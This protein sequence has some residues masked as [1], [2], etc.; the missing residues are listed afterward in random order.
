MAFQEV[1]RER[2][3]RRRAAPD[4]DALPPDLAEALDDLREARAEAREEG[5]PEPSDAALSNADRL[6]RAMYGIWPR[7]YWIYP[8]PD[9]EIA[10]DAQ[11]GF[12][13]SIAVLCDPRGGA[14]CLVN[15]DGRQSR[16]TYP[17]ARKLPDTFLRDALGALRPGNGSK[18]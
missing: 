4:G 7:R 3:S 15:I 12:D 16:K 9:G 1:E 11:A 5:F 8:M 6:L 13:R 2:S 14:R 10:I 18:G 17:A